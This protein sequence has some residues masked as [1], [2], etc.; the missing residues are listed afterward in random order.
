MAVGALSGGPKAK[1]RKKKH[2]VTPT[3]KETSQTVSNK[4][5]S[6]S[7]GRSRK[8]FP[9]SQG[10]PQKSLES[11]PRRTRTRQTREPCLASTPVRGSYADRVPRILESPVGVDQETK[12]SARVLTP[13]K[14]F[15]QNLQLIFS[16]DLSPKTSLPS[17]DV[18]VVVP[19]QRPD[20]KS[21]HSGPTMTTRLRKRIEYQHPKGALTRQTRAKANGETRRV[22]AAGRRGRKRKL[23]T[24]ATAVQPFGRVRPRFNLEMPE[25]AEKG[26]LSLTHTTL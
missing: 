1:S 9:I 13:L 2:E 22:P 7:N 6:R 11:T 18:D 16:L 15:D 19:V 10:S 24:E 4:A 25:E 5:T 26:N 14:V 12:Q 21:Q 23:D 17:S 8:K 20:T 3:K